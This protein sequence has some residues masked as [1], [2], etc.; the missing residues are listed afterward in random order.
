M[1]IK[2]ALITH[3]RLRKHADT[4]RGAARPLLVFR[5]PFSLQSF[6]LLCS[7]CSKSCNQTSFVL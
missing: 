2:G 1:V 6:P 5:T 7:V 3:K 4:H